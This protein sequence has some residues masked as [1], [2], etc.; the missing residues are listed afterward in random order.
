MTV[1]DGG[2]ASLATRCPATQAC[3]LSG[4][5]GLIDEDKPPGVEIELSL[6]PRLAGSLH[7]AT[8]LFAC[9]RCLFL[10]VMPRLLKKCQT[11]AGQA[12]TRRSAASR[13]AIS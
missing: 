7:I 12:E 9:M 11:V 13:S 6:V 10:N 2:A 3:H 1:R 4:S 5:P 8:L